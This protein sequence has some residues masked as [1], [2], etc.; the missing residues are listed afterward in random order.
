[1]PCCSGNER[2]RPLRTLVTLIIDVLF[3]R[4]E[5][6]GGVVREGSGGA[7]SEVDYSSFYRKFKMNKRRYVCRSVQIIRDWVRS[8]KRFAAALSR[9]AIVMTR[10]QAV[11]NRVIILELNAV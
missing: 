10:A 7:Q 3:H 11:L 8:S 5:E 2:R 1:M 4:S 6:K 9:E